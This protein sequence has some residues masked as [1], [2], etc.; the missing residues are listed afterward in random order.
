MWPCSR[1]MLVG[2]VLHLVGIEVIDDG[3]DTGSA[4]VGDELGRL[5]DRLGAVVV[6]SS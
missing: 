6:G 1:R 4:Q 3:R 5:F 2:E